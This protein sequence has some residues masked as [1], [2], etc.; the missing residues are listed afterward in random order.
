MIMKIFWESDKYFGS[1]L[2]LWRLSPFIDKKEGIC[3]NRIVVTIAKKYSYF[4][5]CGGNKVE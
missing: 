3:C 5:Q 2:R 4:S 1:T